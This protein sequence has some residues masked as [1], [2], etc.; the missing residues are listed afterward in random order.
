MNKEL[1]NITKKLE[2]SFDAK[3]SYEFNQV[4]VIVDAEKILE[5]AKSL[6]EEHGFEMLASET[7]IDYLGQAG[8]RF[9]LVYQFNSYAKKI[10]LE[11]RVP[12]SGDDPIIESITSVYP[13]ADW[14]ER[15]IYDMFGI[16][17]ANHPDMRRILM[18]DDWEG[19]PLRKDYPLGYEEVQFSFNYEEIQ[20]RKPHPKS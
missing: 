14:L 11:V 12:L 17:F 16:Q 1:K 9:N 19:N 2:E 13:N 7:A 5:L 20:K 6:K 4:R 18:P 10:R 8:A 3:T 15:E